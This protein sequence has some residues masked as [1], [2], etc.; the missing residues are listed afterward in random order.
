[1]CSQPDSP[2]A[3]G[4]GTAR[5]NTESPALRYG[6]YLLMTGLGVTLTFLSP[7]LREIMREF[8]VGLAQG[9][10][11]TGAVGAGGVA[12]ILAVGLISDRFSK[13]KLVLAGSVI[14]SLTLPLISTASSY[15]VLLLLLAIVGMGTRVLDTLSNAVIK[16]GYTEN[17]GRYLNLMHAFVSIGAILGPVLSGNL[18]PLLG[19]RP[20]L[21]IIGGLCLVTC[22]VFLRIT[23]GIQTA[24]AAAKTPAVSILAPLRDPRM[25]VICAITLLYVGHQASMTTWL[26]TCFSEVFGIEERWAA[27]SVSL[28]WLGIVFGRLF[29]TKI[30][31]PDRAK[32][33]LIWGQLLGGLCLL[34]GVLSHNPAVF[35]VSVFLSGLLSG[36][37]LPLLLDVGCGYHPEASG[38]AM[39]LVFL[40]INISPLIFPVL[41]GAVGDASGLGTGF[42]V[43]A[44]L[45]IAAAAP[46]LLMG[47]EKK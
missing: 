24:P 41:V 11:V 16:D 29:C 45:L 36:A 30:Y 32:A 47:K 25:W 12:A 9:G 6:M 19:W 2:P 13:K 28:Y 31:R 10:L 34:G 38:A 14:F 40:V 27:Y 35:G 3:A 43:A 39:S 37:A 8:S 15:W 4:G 20:V 33:L 26:P 5:Q 23:R 44:A 18:L 17:S 7:M 22:A 42:L 21:L 1:M 46:G